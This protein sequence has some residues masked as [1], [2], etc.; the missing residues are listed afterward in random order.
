[1]EIASR[2]RCVGGMTRFASLKV[3]GT[4]TDHRL[5]LT[6][7]LLSLIHRPGNLSRTVSKINGDSVENRKLF[8]PPCIYI[9]GVYTT[10]LYNAPAEGVEFFN[11][12]SAPKM[13]Y[14]LGGGGKSLTICAFVWK[15][16][17]NVTDGRTDRQT[18]VINNIALCMVTR[19]KNGNGTGNL[20]KTFQLN[21]RQT[22]ITQYIIQL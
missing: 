10:I 12:G 2:P 9:H 20:S 18:D 3:I 6:Y 21:P 4:D 19:D 11:S 22:E 15:Q 1:M 17:Q 16:Y 7:N 5:R 13:G 8:P 14:A